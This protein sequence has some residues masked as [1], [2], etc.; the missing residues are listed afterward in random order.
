M[1]NPIPTIIPPGLLQKLKKEQDELRAQIILSKPPYPIHIISGC[2]SALIG[3]DI[4]SVF[5][6]FSY[7][8][9]KELEI[10]TKRS[11]LPLPY[12]PG[13]LAF[14]EI[15]NLLLAYTKLKTKPDLIMVD[16]Q[17][18]M[19][20]RRMGIATH[21]GIKLQVP[22]IG[23]GKSKLFGTYSEPDLAPGSFTSVTHKEEV[24]GIALR[25][26]LRSNPLF[27]SPG[28][29]CD[30]ETAKNLVLAT[31]RGYRLPEPTRLADK[32][33]KI[34]KPAQSL[35]E[36]ARTMNQMIKPN[37]PAPDFSLPDQDDTIRT[38]SD[39]K[40]K[41]LVVYFY[42]KDDTPG[43][44]KEACSFRD[45]SHKL[46]KR[47][48]AVVGVSKDSVKSHKKFV[49]KYSLPFTLLSDPEKVMIHAYGAWGTK[50]FMGREYDGILRTTFLIDPTGIV[51][52]VYENVKPDEHA[53]A[54]LQD[55]EALSV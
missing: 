22:T 43:C 53:I 17:G 35:E 47:E 31:L 1:W 49:D 16:G 24:L 8:D 3:D 20:P 13:F 19:H 27:I 34:L 41:W 44:T 51:K 48:V 21:L 55:I 6:T 39:Y 14:R 15:P 32:Y 25:S 52:K 9:L 38:L 12:I 45:N 46:L 42:P 28:Y 30:I 2:D 5:V 18:I 11:P 36:K 7:P 10:V 37:T 54:I 33:S 23:V 4:F 40:G 29:L 26:K 50:K